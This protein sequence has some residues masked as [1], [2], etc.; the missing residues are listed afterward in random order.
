LFKFLK[1]L[2]LLSQKLKQISQLPIFL[3][4]VQVIILSSLRQNW[5]VISFSMVFWEV[6]APFCEGLAGKYRWSTLQIFLY[7]LFLFI[8]FPSQAILLKT[9]GKL[10]RSRMDIIEKFGIK[11]GGGYE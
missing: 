2:W 5:W 11:K 4:R 9:V 3:H 7:I 6:H 10:R 8:I 1:I